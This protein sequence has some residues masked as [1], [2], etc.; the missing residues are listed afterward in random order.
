[1]LTFQGL[2]RTQLRALPVADKR[3]IPLDQGAPSTLPFQAARRPAS[4]QQPQFSQLPAVALA[5][6]CMSDTACKLSIKVTT[7]KVLCNNHLRCGVLC[8]R[9]TL[10]KKHH[11]DCIM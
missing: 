6:I 9:E 4:K 1:M 11:T 7:V 8:K 3:M 10:P 2:V 5:D